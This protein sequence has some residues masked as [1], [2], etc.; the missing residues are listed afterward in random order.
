MNVAQQKMKLKHS[1]TKNN[2]I[3]VWNVLSCKKPTFIVQEVN[4]YSEQCNDTCSIMILEK[5]NQ[6]FSKFFQSSSL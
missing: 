5:N 6:C 1:C 2:L 4:K 3:E